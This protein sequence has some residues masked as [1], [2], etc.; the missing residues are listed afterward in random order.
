MQT[1][2]LELAEL[3]RALV[4][5]HE[6]LNSDDFLARQAR[7]VALESE[8]EA[9]LARLKAE[10]ADAEARMGEERRQLAA[11]LEADERAVE[12]AQA[13]MYEHCAQYLEGADLRGPSV[14]DD[15]ILFS[16]DEYSSA[17]A[18]GALSD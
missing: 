7:L 10:M 9:T 16:E 12:I 5:A 8:L 13:A 15:A 18:N 6:R 11:S 14:P 4:A 1:A 17:R 3:S 2:D